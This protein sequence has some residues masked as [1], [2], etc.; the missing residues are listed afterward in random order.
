MVAMALFGLLLATIT[1][2]ISC[3]VFAISSCRDTVQ[4][5]VDARLVFDRMAIDFSKMVKRQDVDSV[6]AKLPGN[7]AMFFYSESPAYVGG[8]GASALSETTK[9][10]VSLVGYRINFQNSN[11][12]NLPVLERLGETLGWTGETSNDASLLQ[13]NSAPGSMVSFTYASGS[14]VPM[15]STTLAGNWSTTIGT[16]GKSYSDG[17]DAD[18]HVLSD[19]VYRMELQFLLTDGTLSQYPILSNPPATWPSGANSPIFYT[20]STADPTMTDD[21]SSYSVGSRWLNTSTGRAYI[22]TN[23]A[24]GSAV[25]SP[26]GV[27][28]VTAVVVV[29]AM[30]DDNSRKIVTATS[31]LVTPLSDAV[32]GTQISKTWLAAVNTSNFGSV[33]GIP[34]MA[35]ARVRV[36]QRYFYLPR[37]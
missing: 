15:L 16:F 20:T 23:A 26:I 27:E 24:S 8:S 30:L 29:L 36:Y 1:Q 34:Q 33:C 9:S 19:T 25:W 21:V 3:L 7:D 31:G 4:V 37:H 13:G 32:N 35:A 28:D 18:Y 10:T 11:Y 12:P 14:A 2:M 6:F 5:D 17:T 22:C